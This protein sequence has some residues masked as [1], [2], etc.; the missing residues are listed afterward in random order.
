MEPRQRAA[1]RIR[2]RQV[3]AAGPR[4]H[5]VGV[6]TAVD[7]TLLDARTFDPGKARA[8][9]QKLTTAGIPVVPISVMTLA[10]IAPIAA[11]LGLRQPMVIEAGGAIAR[12]KEEGWDVEPCG[13]PAE[14]F[15]GVV[16]EI[17]D[18]SGA[19]LLVYSAMEESA[20][21]QVSGRSGEMLRASTSRCFSEP[22]V[23]ESGDLEA[24][25]RAAAAIGF[26]VRR[27]RRFFHL[28]RQCD[29]GE[30]FTRLREE[31]GCDV[32]IAVGGSPVDAEFLMRADFPIIVPAPDGSIDAE[33]LAT[34][35]GA[36]IA[37]S[38]APAG[39][40]AAVEETV[41]MATSKRRIRSAAS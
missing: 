10:E 21:A 13:P 3:R 41:R 6:F 12:W 25:K 8:V 34:V 7:G 14:T 27:G 31:L 32:A 4:N 15:L 29:E 33:L 18:R 26:S 5:R 16:T 9:V 39:W 37:P 23:I 38:P 19:N 1:V 2:P 11:D 22:F 24:V 36:R 28:C 40:A 17:E 20:A 30:A 35:P